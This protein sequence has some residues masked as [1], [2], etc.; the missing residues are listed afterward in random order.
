MSPLTLWLI[1]KKRNMIQIVVSAIRA[2]CIVR[3]ILSVY[4]NS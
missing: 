3:P 1:Q 2:D 4:A